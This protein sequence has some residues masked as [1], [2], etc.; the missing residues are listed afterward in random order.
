MPA[1]DYVSVSAERDVSCVGHFHHANLSR[2]LSVIQGHLLAASLEMLIPLGISFPFT[3]E[4]FWIFEIG[5]QFMF[6]HAHIY[7]RQ[8]LTPILIM[9]YI[10]AVFGKSGKS[11]NVEYKVFS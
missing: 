1:H 4:A 5:C 11:M 6:S 3:P 2:V 7:W 8:R 9:V 10:C